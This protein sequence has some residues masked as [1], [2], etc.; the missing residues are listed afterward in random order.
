MSYNGLGRRLCRRYSDM[1]TFGLA[2][3]PCVPFSMFLD[4]C[5]HSEIILT[6]DGQY[7]IYLDD[8]FSMVLPDL[9]NS[10]MERYV[11]RVRGRW[12]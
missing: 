10:R 8:T 12:K 5:V 11:Q 4:Y 3:G 6:D 7:G 9:L 1:S 2:G